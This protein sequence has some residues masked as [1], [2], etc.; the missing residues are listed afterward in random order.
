MP[1]HF[2]CFLLLLFFNGEAGREQEL[3][4]SRISFFFF[5]ILSKPFHEICFLSEIRVVT[6]IPDSCAFSISVFSALQAVLLLCFLLSCASRGASLEQTG[7]YWSPFTAEKRKKKKRFHQ[8]N[9]NLRWLFF[10]AEG[11]SEGSTVCF[12]QRVH[13]EIWIARAAQMAK[14]VQTGAGGVGGAG[15]RRRFRRRFRR[16]PV[17]TSALTQAGRR[18]PPSVAFLHAPPALGRQVCSNTICPAAPSSPALAHLCIT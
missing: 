5:L 11:V 2:V 9:H 17:G 6:F 14:L 18:Q 16:P 12:L 13:I 3:C 7:R 8:K 15:G 1:F 10:S 4:P